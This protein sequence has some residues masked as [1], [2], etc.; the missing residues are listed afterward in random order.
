MILIKSVRVRKLLGNLGSQ[1]DIKVTLYKKSFKR[2]LIGFS[3]NG[4]VFWNDISYSDIGRYSKYTDDEL[5]NDFIDINSKREKT[6]Y[7]IIQDPYLDKPPKERS[8]G[9]D[10]YYLNN[11]AI[12]EIKWLDNNNQSTGTKIWSDLEGN[13]LNIQKGLTQSTKGFITKIS[14]ILAPK[15]YLG[16]NKILYQTNSGLSSDLDQQINF[17]G[18]VKDKDII[19]QIISLW[20]NQV[21]N[22][23][24]LALC[25]PDN[26]FCELIDF[27]NPVDELVERNAKQDN[28]FRSEDPISDDK[29]NLLFQID[30][31]LNI[32]PR[33]DF[34]FKI[35]IGELPVDPLLT[36]FDFGDEDQD[37]SLLDDEFIEVD[38]EGSDEQLNLLLESDFG[39]SDGVDS[40]IGTDDTITKLQSQTSGGS[41]Q[42]QFQKSL[43]VNG[44][45]IL[46]GE[47]P[48][49]L[50][51]KLDFVN[52]RIERN[53]A[54]KL[55]KLN[56]EFKKEF[57]HDMKITDGYRTF[58]IQNKIFDWNYF[59]TGFNPYTNRIDPKGK[60]RKIG[61]FSKGRPSGISASKPGTSLHGWGQAVDID[62]FGRGPGN[63]YF[64]WMERNASKYGWVNPRW[65]KIPGPSYEPWH[66]EY[67][68]VDLFKSNPIS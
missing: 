2:V 46:N 47:L 57:G 25:D 53:A 59:N 68:G 63:K 28:I 62:G 8:F 31:Q 15:S 22:Y 34:N 65:T 16:E 67:N 27:I 6:I 1:F 49:S 10:P 5:I 37:L 35:F 21:P 9:F 33:E 23:D 4:S 44:V 13:E 64:D 38:F 42:K 29:I 14:Q 40:G 41:G 60:G 3:N 18:N 52:R 48:E 43:V 58:E 54:L 36:G 55:N 66:W 24:D 51:M 61:S 20:K 50:L 11:G 32:K 7:E 19:N 39:E 17:S 56:I 30:S 26:E 45:K 12:V